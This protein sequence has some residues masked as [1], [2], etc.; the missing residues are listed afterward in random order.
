MANSHIVQS[1]LY[2][3]SFLQVSLLC[4]NNNQVQIQLSERSVLSCNTTVVLSMQYPFS[5]GIAFYIHMT[6]RPELTAATYDTYPGARE[7]KLKK[8]VIVPVLWLE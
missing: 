6:L 2:S 5:V 3:G 4:N 7:E 1:I 8:H